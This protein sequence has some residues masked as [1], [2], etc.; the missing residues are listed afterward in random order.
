MRKIKMFL[1]GI[2]LTG[3]RVLS[4]QDIQITGTVTD[5][6]G[7]PL[8][9]ATVIEKN[10]VNNTS[11][12]ALGRYTINVPGTATLVFSFIG[13]KNNEQAVTGRT[14]INVTLDN[15]AVALD[16]VMVVAYGTTARERFTGSVAMIKRS[17]L[18]R[19]ETS[20]IS[21]ALEGAA[22]G[23]QI[24][25]TSGQPGVDAIIRIRGLGSIAAGSAPL[26]VVD[27]VPYGGLLSSITPQDIESFS[28][29]KDAAATSMYGARGSNGVVMITTRK[30]E[31][32]RLQ[33]NFE[34]RA[35]INARGV[36]AYEVI[37]NPAEYYELTWEAQ[38]NGLVESG[39]DAATAGV[40]TSRNLIP[41]VL[42][43]NVY[44]DVPD[45]GLVDSITGKI[46]PAAAGRKWNENWLSDPFKNNLRQEY[47]LNVSGG[48][49]NTDAY[50]SAGYVDDEGYIDKSDFR[51]I[52]IRGKIDQRLG[53]IFKTGLNVGFAQTSANSPIGT[54]GSS[55]AS[56]IFY[57]S[58]IVAPIYPVHKYDLATGQPI[59]GAGG[60]QEYDFGAH[61]V[62]NGAPSNNVRPF[63]AEQNPLYVLQNDLAHSVRDNLSSRAY[64]EVTLPGGFT[65]TVNMAYDVF[66][67]NTVGYS[68]PF[69]GSGKSTGGTGYRTSQRYEEFNTNQLLNYARV[70]GKH[71]INAL[72][73]HEVKSDSD[74]YLY[75]EKRQYYD[76]FN[77]ELVNAG[78]MSA[79]TSYTEKYRMESFL[80]RVEYGYD[81]KYMFSGSFRRDASSK[82]YPNRLWGNFWSVGA[83]WHVKS[84]SFLAGVRQLNT[85]RLRASYGTQGNDAVKGSNLYLDQ[86]DI[87]SDG[88]YPSPVL[89]Y[90]G[91]PDLTW[92]KSTNLTLGLES[93]FFSRVT[94][95]VDYFIK[96]TRDMIY[97]KLLPISVGEPAWVWVNQIDM[98]NSGWEIEAAVD[99]LK[100]LNV[101]W[102]VAANITTLK[103]ELTKL[104]ADK[105]DP[106]G[107][108]SGNY[109]WKT[110]GSI[111][112]WYM[113]LYA[114]VDEATGKSLWYRDD[115][116]GNRHTTAEYAE[117][118]YY[119]TGK[120]AF[121]DFYGG[122][123]TSVTAYGFDLSVQT[124]FQ[125]GGYAYDSF[126]AT[127]MQGGNLKGQNWHV[128]AFNRWTPTNTH[129]GVPRL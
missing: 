119:E 56:N 42:G 63:A 20:S 120:S 106:R 3:V 2:A 16:D 112:D 127:L 76:P 34:A 84:E 73:G 98:K 8:P 40:N 61:N 62:E 13:T 107:Y 88:T 94:L 129:T 87:T 6:G 103:N 51:R 114:G 27:G 102:T 80:S 36:P 82:F 19:G 43:Y 12:D 68:N 116:Q 22:A 83:A 71:K 86:Y 65:F 97:D 30:G 67:V 5:G 113:P 96:E 58:Q 74:L 11:T 78:T 110:G 118:T 52:N 32:K 23:V 50:F 81:N 18:Q 85:L 10:G 121:P 115:E 124:A 66:N 46:N 1:T 38:R 26:L 45:T 4:A 95:N 122:L 128:D 79:L 126:Y 101:T 24:A 111:Y 7:E 15:D 70:F 49:K 117:A 9:G 44:K 33:I 92:E 109:W 59:M 31:G 64:V 108:Q 125:M 89:T 21:K 105:T 41:G 91:A 77:P 54:T 93:K 14:V 99:V 48:G 90:R 37:D 72:L 25:S 53:E 75:G 60:E 55:S 69:S 123:S 28:I 104:P 100:T 57:F 35:G 39:V 47:Y 17:T 29:L